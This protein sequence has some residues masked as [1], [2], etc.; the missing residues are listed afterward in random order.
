[1]NDSADTSS[2]ADAQNTTGPVSA[3]GFVEHPQRANILGELHARPFLPLRLPSRLYHFAFLTDNQQAKDDRQAVLAMAAR[4]GVAPPGEDA[5]FHHFDLGPWQL[6]WEQHTEFTTYLWSTSLEAEEP[7]EKPN[8]IG[9]GEFAFQGPGQLVS[10]VHLS[11]IER[12]QLIGNLA[13]YFD[14]QSLCIIEA[15][16]KCARVSTD[17]QVDPV[18]MTRILVEST[19]LTK[20]RAGRLTQRLLEIETYRTL[21]LLGLPVARSIRPDLDRMEAELAAITGDAAKIENH[22]QSQAL[23]RR[24][25]TVAGGLEA[26]AARTAF[27][28][29]ATRAYYDIINDRLNIIKEVPHEQYVSI[30]AFF[31]RRLKPAIETCNAAEKRQARLSDQL[32]RA[33]DLLSTGIQSDLEKQNRDL[34][35]SMNRRARMQLRLQ[36]TVEGLSVAAISY[37]VVGL[38]SYLASGLKDA[39]ALHEKISAGIITGVA[40]PV[41]VLVVW[42]SMRA[43]KRRMHV[44]DEAEDDE[45]KR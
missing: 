33:T 30:S 3:L 2:M 1:M 20:T 11:C 34:L 15:A 13:E 21:A 6:R 35:K 39:G 40:V 24:L 26:Q 41:V 44:R 23:L 42:L 43:I 12:R 38:V 28:F 9:A 27:R 25:G 31:N 17:F 4:R 32:A 37:Y 19:G 16:D 18:G 5:R 7:F 36:Q 14:P 29:A 45:T 22:R 8:P 10:A